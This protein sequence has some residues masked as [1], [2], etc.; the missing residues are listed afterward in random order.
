MTSLSQ[1]S[2][3]CSF[4]ISASL[5]QQDGTGPAPT[6]RPAGREAVSVG[7]VHTPRAPGQ[8]GEEGEVVVG[9]Q[10]AAVWVYDVSERGGEGAVVVTTACRV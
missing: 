4:P 7:P 9:V 2:T 10:G 1:P 5:T 3:L 8:A 6:A